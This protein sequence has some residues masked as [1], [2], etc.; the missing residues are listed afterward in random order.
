[1]SRNSQAQKQQ[2][3]IR[4]AQQAA[5]LM[6]EDGVQD[7]AA[8][9]R[10]AARQLGTPDSHSLPTNGEIEQEL[11]SYQALYQRDEQRERLRFL[12]QQAL[13][14][15]ELLELFDP[16]LTGSV[17]NGTATRHSDINLH[18]FPESA[19]ELEMFL[20]NRKMRYKYSEKRFHFGNEI[21]MI[22]ILMLH[23]AGAAIEVAIFSLD[24]LRRAPRAPVE[25]RPMDRAKPHQVR[26]LLAMD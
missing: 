25:G 4:I 23:E 9:K 20:L 18:V 15:M 19:K 12:R 1:M 21:R 16:R 11:R 13:A 22:P 3:R 5:R 7:Y 2:M 8:A 26:A 6:A 14:A 24:D 10:K 17:L